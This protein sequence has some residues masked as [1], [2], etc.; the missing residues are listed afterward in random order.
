MESG[1]DYSIR[2]TFRPCYFVVGSNFN[3]VLLSK[4]TDHTFKIVSVKDAL[5][6]GFRK[7][8]EFA[9]VVMVRI[10][11]VDTVTDSNQFSSGMV[12]TSVLILVGYLPCAL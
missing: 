6:D 3:T 4:S 5:F 1:V 8:V 10:V 9:F 2:S 7:I 11:F 12:A